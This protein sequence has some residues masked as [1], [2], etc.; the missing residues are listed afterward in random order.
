[1]DLASYSEFPVIVH[2]TARRYKPEDANFEFGLPMAGR[3]EVFSEGLT[4]E[5]ADV[6]AQR[7]S[8]SAQL[9]HSRRQAPIGRGNRAIDNKKTKS[10]AVL[11][12]QC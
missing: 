3:S 2:Q 4:I 10:R 12:I 11:K 5:Y 6:R 8:S 7:L 9:K 1:M